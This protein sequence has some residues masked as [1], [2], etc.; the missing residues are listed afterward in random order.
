MSK[1]DARRTTM[2][3][4][5]IEGLDVA[6]LRRVTL[7]AV[8]LTVAGAGMVLAVA[9]PGIVPPN[10][11]VGAGV[12]LAALLLGYAAA[13]AVDTAD[14]TVR[15]PR[16]VRSAGGELVAVVPGA[17]E[18]EDA[19]PLARAVLEAREGDERILLGLAAAG[20]DLQRTVAWTEALSEALAE[21]GVSVLR[22]DLARG[23]TTSPG[24]VEVI[25]EGRRI[26]SVVQFDDDLLLARMGAGHDV[27]GALAVLPS[28]HS[29][30][31]RDLDVLLVALPTAA[32]REV[33]VA[34]KGLDHVLV[35]AERDTTARVDLI[36]ALDALEGAGTSAQAVL[37]DDRTVARLS[38]TAP[39]AET[40]DDSVAQ[41]PASSGDSGEHGSGIAS[42][43]VEPGLAPAQADPAPV[44][45][46]AQ[47][48]PVPAPDEVS[49]SATADDDEEPEDAQGPADEGGWGTVRRVAGSRADTDDVVRLPEHEVRPAPTP[50]NVT[51]PEPEPTTPQPAPE[52]AT[53][54]EPEP[55]AATPEPAHDPAPVEGR[56]EDVL[57][58][59]GAERAANRITAR[60]RPMPFSPGKHAGEA[61]ADQ[62]AE[63]STE[64]DERPRLTWAA[65]SPER[66]RPVDAVPDLE[67]RR[68]RDEAPTD[69]LPGAVGPADTGD[70]HRSARHQSVPASE[71]APRE[72][73]P[74]RTTAQ[75]AILLEELEGRDEGRPQ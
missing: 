69:E 60:E 34:T 47:D 1:R 13:L 11:L 36:A 24:L 8:A 5:L 39:E 66:A 68:G 33:V 43:P 22:V 56:D 14:L 15:G 9:A 19:R 4:W 21:E 35:V 27:A 29:R 67:T 6:E 41:A 52:V 59:A 25:R 18:V 64:Q 45:P 2:P 23:R 75:L 55:A 32:S 20:R 42:A 71:A 48:E 53:E 44:E 40:A 70:R 46:P 74:L 62:V 10:P 61:P 7:V 54:P 12:G 49:V 37:V 51:A 73:D 58:H 38:R 65:P 17:A 63:G 28:L 72:D 16:H 26:A 30:L 50:E 57:R 31:P 3:L